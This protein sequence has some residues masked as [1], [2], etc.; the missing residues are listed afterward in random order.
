[1]QPSGARPDKVSDTESLYEGLTL[2]A[3]KDGA[4]RLTDTALENRFFLSHLL[5]SLRDLDKA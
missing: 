5:T 1:M 3:K 4:Y 2:Q